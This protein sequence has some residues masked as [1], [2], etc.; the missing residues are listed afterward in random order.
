[1]FVCCTPNRY[2][3]AAPVPRCLLNGDETTGTSVI[4]VTANKFDSGDILMQ[5][6]YALTKQQDSAGQ[7]SEYLGD[8]IGSDLLAYLADKGSS[9]VVEVL[10]NVESFIAKARFVRVAMS[11]G[12]P[13]LSASCLTFWSPVVLALL[14]RKAARPN[15]R[16][17][18]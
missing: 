3:G 10:R 5:K 18:T 7:A 1:M 6:E 9:D 16:N 4:R 8:M 17:A 13:T 2:R 14:F 15:G 12:G 11:V